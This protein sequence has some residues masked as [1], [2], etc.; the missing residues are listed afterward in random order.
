MAC[1]IAYLCTVWTAHT[2]G[3]S[4]I[5]IVANNTWQVLILGDAGVH[6]SLCGMLKDEQSAECCFVE[7]Q[8]ITTAQHMPTN[9]EHLVAASPG[10]WVLCSEV[11]LLHGSH[12]H[13]HSDRGHHRPAFLLT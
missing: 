11:F 9:I 4:C 10:E 13:M 5:G 8:V 2:S 12:L 7:L 6:P 1:V 3:K